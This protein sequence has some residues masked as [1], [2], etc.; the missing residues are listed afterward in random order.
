MRIH[1]LPRKVSGVRGNW[2]PEFLPGAPLK[3]GWI[4]FTPRSDHPSSGPRLRNTILKQIGRGYIL[5]YVPLTP[6]KPNRH[7]RPLTPGE[8]EWH[9]RSAG[10]LTAVYRVID[11]RFHA[12][13]LVSTQ[14]F[15]DIQGRWAYNGKQSR[16]SEAFLIVEAWNIVGWPKA[17]EILGL[18]SADRACEQLSSGI[19]VLTDEDRS[20]LDHLEL[21][22]VD[23][24]GDG[25]AARY[26]IRESQKR[27]Q[28]KNV[29]ANSITADRHLYQ[30]FAA[31]E[32]STREIRLR[33]L[34]GTGTWWRS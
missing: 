3:D 17:R 21:T 7:G 26:F 11:H 27:N 24:P 10:S 29:T 9:A 16:W 1:D 22:P 31:I 28:E 13:E 6:P 32:G 12:S 30:D 34:N 20:R 14:E 8:K 33:L 4:G 2:L 18:E 5:E 23:L 19:K 15:E 25:M